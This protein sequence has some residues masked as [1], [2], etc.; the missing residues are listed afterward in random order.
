M[1]ILFVC[2]GNTC[3]SCMAEAIFNNICADTEMTASSAGVSI[4]AGS[5]TSD[6]SVEVVKSKLGVD[7]SSRYAVQ[8][9]VDMIKEADLVL[10]M[11]ASHKRM[12]ISDY[13][14]FKNK[15]FTLGEYVGVKGNI[16]DP[17]GGDIVVY[18]KAFETLMD[19]INLLLDKFKEDSSIK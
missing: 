14:I 16:A 3:R 17:Y 12:I 1:K 4:D 6:N 5:M 11:T 2:T 18:Q 15:V 19:R 9:E 13:P 8:L 7:L 10:T